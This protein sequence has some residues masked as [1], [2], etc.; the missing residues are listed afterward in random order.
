M[1]MLKKLM[2]MVIENPFTVH[3]IAIIIIFAITTSIVFNN[4]TTLSFISST[5]LM[6]SG[7]TIEI[8]LFFGIIN[9]R[10]K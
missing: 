3:T 5:H 8:G 9:N 1:K 6:A 2:E 10:I 4:Q 7:A